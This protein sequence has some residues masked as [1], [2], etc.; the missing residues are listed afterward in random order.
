MTKRLSLSFT[1]KEVKCGWATNRETGDFLSEL[2]H[3]RVK[4]GMKSYYTR[5]SS[6]NQ[7]VWSTWP[8]AGRRNVSQAARG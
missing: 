2:E 3:L 4:R 1:A 8:S 6:T 7:A 5:N